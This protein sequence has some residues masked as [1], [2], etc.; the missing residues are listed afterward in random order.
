MALEMLPC[1][2][3]FTN[4]ILASKDNRTR[5]R[6]KWLDVENSRL[7]GDISHTGLALA[8]EGGECSKRS[9]ENA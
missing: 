5:R 9:Q 3:R 1:L 4:H 7:S 8:V 2:E 6:A